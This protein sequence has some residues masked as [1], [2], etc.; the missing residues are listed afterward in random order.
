[1]SAVAVKWKN[2]TF[3]GFWFLTNFLR[4][5]G[6]QE[7][8]VK[9]VIADLTQQYDKYRGP[10]G[11]DFCPTFLATTV[12]DNLGDIEMFQPISEEKIGSTTFVLEND[13][14]ILICPF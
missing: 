13:G 14:C 10:M 3:Q 11:K 4:G 9:E 5:E 1:M 7:N 6:L 8:A 12:R 2:E